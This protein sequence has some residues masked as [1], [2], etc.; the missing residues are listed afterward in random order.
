MTANRKEEVFVRIPKSL[1]EQ[2]AEIAARE[3]RSVTGC[4]RS[5]VRAGIAQRSEQAAARGDVR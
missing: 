5:M 2:L 1:Y 3:D 4:V